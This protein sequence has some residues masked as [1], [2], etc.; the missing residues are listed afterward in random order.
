MT[1]ETTALRVLLAVVMTFMAVPALSQDMSEDHA[2]TSVADF[3]KEVFPTKGYADTLTMFHWNSGATPD[4]LRGYKLTL[5]EAQ[6][7]RFR[8]LGFHYTRG[9]G[10]GMPDGKLPLEVRLYDDTS[11]PDS[12]KASFQWYVEGKEN[13]F[14]DTT[15]VD[16][17]GLVLSPGT[18]FLVY[19]GYL[20]NVIKYPYDQ[21]TT[22]IQGEQSAITVVLESIPLLPP[23]GKGEVKG[24]NTITEFTSHDGSLYNGDSLMTQYDDFG[25][26][27]KSIARGK[28]PT[29][30]DIVEA[31]DYDGFGRERR[32]WLP[33][34][35]SSDLPLAKLLGDANSLDYGEAYADREPYSFSVYEDSPLSRTLATYGPGEEW[36]AKGKGVVTASLANVIGSDTLGCVMLKVVDGAGDATIRSDGEYA[37]GTL[38]VTRTEDEDGNVSFSFVDRGGRT[39]LERGMLNEDGARHALDTYYV[40]DPFDNLLAVLPPAVSSGTL[41]GEVDKELMDKYAYQ[42]RYDIHDRMIAKKLPGR[43]W[44][45]YAYDRNDNV[46]FSQDPEQRRRGKSAFVLRDSLGRQCVTGTC[47]FTFQRGY[48]IQGEVYCHYTGEESEL[49]GYVSTGI[50]LTDAR[51]VTATYYDSYDFID[52]LCKDAKLPNGDLEYG[53]QADYVIGLVTGR[54]NSVLEAT[55]SA[56]PRKL[57]SVIK[58][59][60]RA[61]PSRMETENLMGGYDVEDTEHDFLGRVTRRHLL[62]NCPH[63]GK[64]IEEEYAY[65][66]DHAGRLLKVEHRINGGEARVLADNQYD[67]LGRL[68]VNKVNGT[69]ALATAYGYNLRSWLTKVTNPAFEEELRYNES[70]GTAKPLYGGNVSSM[71]WKAGHDDRS[72]L[73]GFTYDGLGRLTAATYGEKDAS[74]KNTGK[75][76]GSY[77]TRYTYDQMGNILTLRRQGLHDDGAYDEIDNLKY[78]YDGNQVVSVEDSAVDPVYKDCFTFVDGADE[79]KEYEYDENGNLTKDLNRGICGIEYNCLNLPSRV[80]FLDGSRIT[81]VYDGGGRK[82]RTDHYVNPLTASVPQLAGGTGTAGDGALVH[83]WTDYCANKVY[84]NDTLSMSLFDGGYVSYDA[85]A[86]GS[87][88]SP[89]YHYYIKDHLGDN[90]VVLGE[91]GEVEQ[92]NHYYPFGGLMGESENLRSSQRYKYNGKEL[93]RTHG[94]YW[95]DYGARTY[96][97]ALARWMT[98]DPLAEKYYGVSPYAYC[99]NSP[100]NSIDSDGQD[101]YYSNNGHFLFQDRKTTSFVYVDNKRLTYKNRVITNEQF[102]RLSS[103][104]YAESSVIYGIANREEMFAIASVHLRNGKAYG[105]DN[106]QAKKMRNTDLSN[107]TETMEMANAAII[108]AILGGHDYSNGA[109]QWDGAEQAMVKKENQDKPSDGRIMYKMNTMGWSMDINHYNSWK[110]AIERKFGM[111]KFTV[112]RIKKANSNYGGMHNKNKIR[113]KSTAQHG[114]TIFWKTH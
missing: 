34:T 15:A 98:Q 54:V 71:E 11:S 77:D 36:H 2:E 49:V 65:A 38:S 101:F 81:Y 78:T 72:R 42:Y 40:Y 7:I 60:H 3:Y 114:L 26:L 17:S 95:Y 21:L 27:S 113:L 13:V 19:G 8:C 47:A 10:S 91:K 41:N 20:E 33:V 108:N 4:S 73:Y 24:W 6:T 45:H 92:V 74:G 104:V 102:I 111:N 48:G 82:L 62:H 23:P 61:R 51:V 94:L 83:T 75:G 89:S 39:V 46:V 50:T 76:G 68:I 84:E 1:K 93:D 87:S 90:R 80:D 85:K 97:P 79:E 52:D 58:Y 67:E 5:T 28:S 66:Y 99:G 96:D 112:P 100:I 109:D 103:T 105:A 30:N 43:G 69:V 64:D 16:T 55:G 106:A 29:G 70:G 18:Y 57:F 107:L 12:Q 56:A 37:S 22:V 86:D 31:R 32:A 53:R 35:S 88:P 63:L 9:L 110:S 25:R 14:A 59:D 44:V